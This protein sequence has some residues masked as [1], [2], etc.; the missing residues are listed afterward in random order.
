MYEQFQIDGPFC[1]MEQ[2]FKIKN[3]YI[4]SSLELAARDG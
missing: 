1:V 3:K 2:L 4:P